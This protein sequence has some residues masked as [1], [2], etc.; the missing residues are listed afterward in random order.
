M[1]YVKIYFYCNSK[2]SA[3]QNEHTSYISY[4]PIWYKKMK[5]VVFLDFII[6]FGI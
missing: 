1:K 2:I 3:A 6:R 5:L 4:N